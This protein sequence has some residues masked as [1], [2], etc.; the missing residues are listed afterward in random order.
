MLQLILKTFIVLLLL[1]PSGR[2]IAQEVLVSQRPVY[3]VGERVELRISTV[4]G[5]LSVSAVATAEVRKGKNKKLWTEFQLNVTINGVDL[6]SG[7]AYV[8]QD[9]WNGYLMHQGVMYRSTSTVT[10]PLRAGDVFEN[11]VLESGPCAN[12]PGKTCMNVRMSEECYGTRRVYNGIEYTCD[13]TPGG[14]IRYVMD[15]SF[16]WPVEFEVLN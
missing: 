4:F 5:D 15:P 14:R 10:F 3:Q 6:F 9:T 12:H 1:I 11:Q 8:Q 13:G 2:S 7:K 16:Q